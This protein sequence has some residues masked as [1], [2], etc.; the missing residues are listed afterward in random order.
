[1]AMR[2]GTHSARRCPSASETGSAAMVGIRP[3]GAIGTVTGGGVRA[4]QIGH[5]ASFGGRQYGIG[6]RSRAGVRDFPRLCWA[7]GLSGSAWD[8]EE[9]RRTPSPIKLSAPTTG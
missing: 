9:A 8:T 5:P 7:A 1:M 3:S 6:A 2:I 4:F